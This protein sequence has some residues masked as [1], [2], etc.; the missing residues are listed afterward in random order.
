MQYMALK[1]SEPSSPHLS[2]AP[3]PRD[4]SP[5]PSP[6]M[7]DFARVP[8][9]R[10][11]SPAFHDLTRAP[12]PASHD[13][14]RAT[15]SIL[16]N[17]VAD[18]RE[19][20]GHLEDGIVSS[21]PRPIPYP[22]TFSTYEKTL[23]SPRMNS[24]HEHKGE[25]LTSPARHT[26]KTYSGDRTPPTGHS[27]AGAGVFTF[28]SVSRSCSSSLKENDYQFAVLHPS[29]SISSSVSYDEYPSYR[30]VGG[31]MKDFYYPTT[32]E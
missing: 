8:S 22:L 18:S 19:P 10:A 30:R 31:I 15:N 7:H 28:P 11:P 29:L 2:R 12:S 5:A 32:Q 21:K 26:F 3:S 23:D 27:K 1:S 16:P 13:F 20:L 24:Y 17:G 14:I 6:S 9:P 25:N 4:Y